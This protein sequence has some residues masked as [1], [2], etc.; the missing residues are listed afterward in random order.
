[1]NWLPTLPE[2]AFVDNDGAVSAMGGTP[3]PASVRP[4]LPIP[5][6]EAC[7]LDL[8]TGEQPS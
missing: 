8:C 7:A 1:M 5:Q 3:L 2:A 4:L 6:R